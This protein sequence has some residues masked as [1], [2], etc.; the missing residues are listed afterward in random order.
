MLLVNLASGRT[1]TYDLNDPDQLREWESVKRSRQ[2]EITGLTLHIEGKHYVLPIPRARFERISCDAGL[3]LHRDGSGKVVGN[4][5][6]LHADDITA[7]VLAYAG[8]RPPMVR[9]S[10]ERLGNPVFLPG[11][12]TP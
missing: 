8:S 4:Q 12:E 9:F 5:I 7:T 11:L 6:A 3:V 2:G 10:V 1:F